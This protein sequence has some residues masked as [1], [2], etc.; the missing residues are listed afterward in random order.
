MLIAIASTDGET[1]NAHFGRADRFLI[2]DIAPGSRSMMSIRKVEPLST[3]ERNH[4]FD[5]QRID[6][7]VEAIKDCRMVYC[8]KIGERP[9]QELEKYGITAIIGNMD[10]Q[11]I[12]EGK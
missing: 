9:R 5:Q 2:Y 3:G 7:V 8:T 12:F 11:S 1:V 6:A 4:S 10:I